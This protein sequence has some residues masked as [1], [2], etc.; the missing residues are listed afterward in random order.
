MELR[1]SAEHIEKAKLQKDNNA[2]EPVRLF[3]YTGTV[4]CN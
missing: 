4:F 1:L 2:N 3:K